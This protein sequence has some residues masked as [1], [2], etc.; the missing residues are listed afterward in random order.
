[1]V[2]SKNGAKQIKISKG[3]LGLVIA[4]CALAVL[5]AFLLILRTKRMRMDM[6]KFGQRLSSG[7]R[8]VFFGDEG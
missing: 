3:T 5:M 6:Q 8:Q 4:V 2:M 7:G 1:M